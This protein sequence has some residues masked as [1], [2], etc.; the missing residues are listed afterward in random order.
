MLLALS[1]PLVYLH[2]LDELQRDEAIIRYSGPTD[3]SAGG[4][5]LS[6]LFAAAEGG[7]LLA[8]PTRG[9][10]RR[11]EREMVRWAQSVGCGSA[12]ASLNPLSRL[13]W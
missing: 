8:S 12:T 1:A 2:C 6:S 13:N 7:R 9:G 4:R 11:L 3:C 10:R 5:H